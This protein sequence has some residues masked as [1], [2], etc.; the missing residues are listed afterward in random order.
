MLSVSTATAGANKFTCPNHHHHHH[1]EKHQKAMA[2]SIASN[3]FPTD[4]YTDSADNFDDEYSP[5]PTQFRRNDHSPP[6]NQQYDSSLESISSSQD[7]LPSPPTSH[8]SNSGSVPAAA[9]FPDNGGYNSTGMVWYLEHPRV[10]YPFTLC[11]SRPPTPQTL[12]AY[13]TATGIT[14]T[15]FEI[16]EEPSKRPHVDLQ[17]IVISCKALENASL[18]IYFGPDSKHNFS[19][20]VG[21]SPPHNSSHLAAEI[22]ATHKALKIS[23]NIANVFGPG[24]IAVMKVIVVTSC[25]LVFKVITQWIEELNEREW[26]GADNCFEGATENRP[27]FERLDR[28]VRE[29]IEEDGLEVVF[30]LVEEEGVAE[31]EKL[32]KEKLAAVVG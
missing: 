1:R 21:D 19:L 31:A 26:E 6:T 2:H 27:A 30:W 13:S 32:A 25:V 4:E 11:I 18:G 24:R 3:E 14:H 28:L 16:P 20:F 22:F 17:T 5:L 23:R 12:T 15:I 9:Q 29:L 7:S 10:F 8:S